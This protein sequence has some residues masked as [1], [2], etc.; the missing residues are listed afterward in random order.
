[1]T[2]PA[3]ISFPD[4]PAAPA[5]A[6][7]LS[8]SQKAFLARKAA[9]LAGTGP[10]FPPESSCGVCGGVG[11]Y[12]CKSCNGTCLNPEGFVPPRGL[13]LEDARQFNGRV[14]VTT[15]LMPGGLCFHCA[16]KAMQACVACEG[17]GFAEGRMELFS[18][19]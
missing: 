7:E 16:G 12:V 8:P 5:A 15:F 6:A 13:V 19:D 1:M 17:T 2:F 10:L 3:V 4:R 18:G 14:D 11:S 9:Y